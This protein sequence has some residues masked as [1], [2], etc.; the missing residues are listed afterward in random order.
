MSEV[1]IDGQKAIVVDGGAGDPFAAKAAEAS[2]GAAVEKP[3]D[4]AVETKPE[5]VKPEVVKVGVTQ[6]ELQAA[7]RAQQSQYDKTI[8][9]FQETAKAASQRAKD[10]ERT[11]K[12]SADDLT[13]AEKDL[14]K[15]KWALEDREEAL[16][17]AEEANEAFFRTVYIGRLAAANEQYGV[18]AEQLEA[19]SEPEEMDAVCLRAELAY[20]KA[21]KHLTL[22]EA[23]SQPEPKKEEPVPAGA[24]APTD[25]GGTGV[26]AP[27]PELS[28]GRG[29]DAMVESLKALPVAQFKWN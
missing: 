22:Q 7:L 18:T 5:A 23:L 15:G 24:S 29:I 8:Q 6:E 11:A 17:E 27:P 20:F 25:V 21:G 4:G 2:N 26:T 14:L 13:D 10:V 16:T 28:K 9:K 1:T 12:L 19:L 3:A